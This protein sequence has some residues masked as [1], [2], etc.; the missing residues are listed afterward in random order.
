MQR[1]DVIELE[2]RRLFEHRLHLRAVFADDVGVVAPRLV[3]VVGEEIDLV[4]EEV[5]VQGAEG[6]EGV[7]REEH[8]VAQV[9]GHHDLRPVHH[10][11][12]DEGEL[13]PAGAQPVALCDDVVFKRVRQR[14]ELS[15]HGL[16]L[17]V[18]HDGQLGVAQREL[19]YGR[20]VVGLHVRDDEVVELPSVQRVGEVF[21]E[22]AADGLVDRVEQNGLF[23]V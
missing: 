15:E 10:R 20:R 13:V 4:G 21:K 16:Y 2:P 12:H 17:I 11:R 14:E 5:T 3:D 8:P 18:A 1:A 22:G 23:V 9:V 6:A 7:G 19:L